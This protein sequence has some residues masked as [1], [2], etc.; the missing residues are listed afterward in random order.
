VAAIQMVLSSIATV[1]ML[2]ILSNWIKP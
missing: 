2:A 1:W